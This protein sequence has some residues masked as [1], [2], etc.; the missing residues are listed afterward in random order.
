M[1]YLFET[2]SDFSILCEY[3]VYICLYLFLNN[4]YIGINDNSELKLKECFVLWIHF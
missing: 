1:I 3:N 2:Y 4:E